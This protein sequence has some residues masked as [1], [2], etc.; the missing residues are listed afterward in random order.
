[1]DLLLLA[2]L[3]ADGNQE[4]KASSAPVWATWVPAVIALL[5]SFLVAWWGG[6]RVDRQIE[7][8]KQATPPELT[9][10][11]EWLEISKDYKELVG[12]KEDV[13]SSEVSEER[14]EIER[15]R[16]VALN[17]AAWERKVISAC[18]DI[19][20][21]KCLMTIS[22]SFIISDFKNGGFPKNIPSFR[23]GKIFLAEVLVVVPLSV[24]LIFLSIYLVWFSIIHPVIYWIFPEFILFIDLKFPWGKGNV[25]FNMW[26]AV[27]VFVVSVLLIGLVNFLI[28]VG[29]SW[30]IGVSGEK[31][32][33]YGYM[34]LLKEKNEADKFMEIVKASSN[35]TNNS[36]RLYFG[37]MDAG[38]RETI[39][40]PERLKGKYMLLLQ[41]FVLALPYWVLNFRYKKNGYNYGEY[42]P[43]IFG[44]T[45]ESLKDEQAEQDGNLKDKK[46]SISRRI[47]LWISKKW[48]SLNR[49]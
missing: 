10:Y 36:Q 30:R 21:Q 24:I 27:G 4:A 49:S 28:N 31:F 22:P 35:V 14:K 38:Y 19:N 41:P 17:R 46:T 5:G 26:E 44:I 25:I 47:A 8:S 20:G 32:A 33:E 9:R 13:E 18:P 15:L 2:H 11:K 40:Y 1:M 16:E 6:R 3:V 7:I 45:E 39:Y 42:K 37:I 29:D 48:E 23:S 12:T 34:C 43:E